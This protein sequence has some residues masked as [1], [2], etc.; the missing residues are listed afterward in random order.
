MATRFVPLAMVA[1]KPSSINTERE[2]ILP[3]P[4]SV[5]IKPT[6]IPAT[7]KVITSATMYLIL[8]KQK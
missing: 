5:L 2:T 1:G 6:S 7:I 8:K 4:A 3:P